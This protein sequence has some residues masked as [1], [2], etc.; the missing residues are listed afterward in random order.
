M[1]PISWKFIGIY[2]PKAYWIKCNTDGATQGCPRLAACGGIFRD[3]SA[4]TL[5]CFARNIGVTYA[6]H[7][8]FIGVMIAIEIANM[9]GLVFTLRLTTP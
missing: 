8:E 7:V 6:F 5:G 2:P 3:S 9:K 4:A 1:L